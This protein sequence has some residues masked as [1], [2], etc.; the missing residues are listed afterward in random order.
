[1]TQSLVPGENHPYYWTRQGISLQELQER[2]ADL[3]AAAGSVGI[4][5]TALGEAV[6]Q[7]QAAAAAATTVVALLEPTITS[8]LTGPTGTG[9]FVQ[10]LFKTSDVNATRPAV[11]PGVSVWWDLGVDASTPPTNMGANDYWIS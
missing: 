10:F 9:Q 1:M 11:D 6:A 3:I 8:K 7:A 5:L 4:D 2:F